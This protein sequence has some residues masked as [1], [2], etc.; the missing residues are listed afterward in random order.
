M[1]KGTY[2]LLACALLLVFALVACGS[3]LTTPLNAGEE[4]TERAATVENEPQALQVDVSQGSRD[5]GW[6]VDEN[7]DIYYIS[8]GTPLTGWQSLNGRWFHFDDDGAAIKGWTTWQGEWRYCDPKTGAMVTNNPVEGAYWADDNGALTPVEGIMEEGGSIP[9]TAVSRTDRTKLVA[10]LEEHASEYLGTI[11]NSWPCSEPGVGMQCAG[12]VDRALYDAGYGKGFYL[13]LSG[14][15][16]ERYWYNDGYM[17]RA[18]EDP[19]TNENCWHVL[20]WVLWAREYDV[21]WRAYRTHE[22]AMAGAQ[23]G[24]FQKG[25]ILIYSWTSIAGY[26]CSGNEHVAFYWGDEDDWSLIWESSPIHDNAIVERS[27]YESYIYVL[28]SS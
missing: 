6:F 18:D 1:R 7:N 9:W 26:D 23:R 3:G 19:Y 5:S 24:E 2:V 21:H 16:Y 15:G 27:E 11:Y 28:T 14:T 12:F 8:K 22:D 13:H 10:Y 4:S 17:Y 25:D 20:G